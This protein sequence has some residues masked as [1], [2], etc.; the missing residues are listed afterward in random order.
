MDIFKKAK[1]A[2][3]DI[4]QERNR[5]DTI[6]SQEVSY[7]SITLVG[8]IQN[9]FQEW[10]YRNGCVSL[11]EYIEIIGADDSSFYKSNPPNPEL[12]LE[13]CQLIINLVFFVRR[14]NFAILD[15]NTELRKPDV[16]EKTIE[17]VTDNIQL[18]LDKNN[19]SL[20][21]IDAEQPKIEIVSKDPEAELA[22]DNLP[23]DYQEKIFEYLAFSNKNNLDK[24]Q[25][26]LTYLNKYLD[27]NHP[28]IKDDTTKSL[29]NFRRIYKSVA[30]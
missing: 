25:A 17:A 2:K 4:F 14:N 9:H 11:K 20:H 19:Y 23:S 22:V 21:S 13:Y 10:P 7:Y 6:L 30:G 1:L 15:K 5:I 8:I 26:I 29:E 16:L 24:K 3:I 18:F 28:L 27:D 12:F